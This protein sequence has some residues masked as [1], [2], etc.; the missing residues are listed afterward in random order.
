MEIL[1]FIRFLGPSV[2]VPFIVV[3]A[4]S[5]FMIWVINRHHRGKDLAPRPCLQCGA[6]IRES[7]CPYCGKDQTM[8]FNIPW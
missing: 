2:V 6:V 5:A 3:V 7:V 1:E 8:R 4:F